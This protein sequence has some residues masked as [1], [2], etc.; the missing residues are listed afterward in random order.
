MP[1]ARAAFGALDAMSDLGISRPFDVRRDG[2]V[3][4][5]GAAVLVLE[6]AEQGARARREHPRLRARLRRHVGRLPPDRAGQGRRGRRRGDP[7]RARRRRP[8][9]RGHRLRQRARHLDPAQRPRRDAGHQGRRSA[10]RAQD[11]PVSSTKSAIGHLLG[12]AGAVEAVATILALR[13]RIAPP[14]LGLRGARGGPGPGLRAGQGPPAGHR[15][16]ARDRASRTPSASAA[17][18]RCCAWRPH[19]DRV[20]P[21]GRGQAL[22]DRAPGGAL[23]PRLADA[24]ALRRPLAPHGR[25]GARGRRRDRRRRARRRPAR[26]LLRAGPVLPRRLARRAARR[27]DRPRAAARRAAPARRSSASSSPAARACRRA[28]R[29]SRGYAR[30][31]RE[32]VALSGK[33]PQISVICGASAGGG[34]YSPALTDFVVMTERGEHVPHRPGRREGGHGRG[35]RR[36]RARRPEGPRPQRRRPLRRAHRLRRGAARPRPARPPARR[37]AGGPP[38]RVALGRAARLRPRRPGAGVRAPWSTT[39]ATSIR[40]IVDGG[41][42]LEWSPRWA[43]NIVCGFARLEGKP[44]G[45]IANQPRYLGGVLDSDSGD[46]GREASSAPATRSASRCSCSSTRPASCPA[47]KQEQGGVIRH[48][49]KLVHAFAEASVPKVTL[50]LRKAFG[51][52]FIAMNSRDLGADYVFAWPQAHA[53]RHGRQAGR[54]DRQ[55]ARHRRRRRSRRPRA[56]STPRRY[57]RRAPD[58]GGRRGRGLRR[59]DRRRRPTPAAGSP[60]PCG[61]WRPWRTRPRGVRNIPL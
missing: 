9:H 13:D 2:F 22:A 58:L 61:R 31:F 42:L 32:H 53:R 20:R 39:S 19:D 56:T 47:R 23:R 29:R 52:A 24:A 4:G 35:R 12:A 54:R 38:P 18:T 10:T 40:G 15:R 55:A 25:Q 36:L 7:R 21:P 3:M 37:Y 27:L 26:V 44:V 6:D 17:T 14:T 48:G 49:A 30:I 45:I 50:V 34:S 8:D 51:G 33:I 5:E 16:Q 28:S 43:R 46:Q 41:R 57:T 59:R 11:I 1:L 60:R